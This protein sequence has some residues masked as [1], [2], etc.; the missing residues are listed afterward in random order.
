MAAAL[1]LFRPI[2]RHRNLAATTIVASALGYLERSVVSER[3]RAKY[4]AY[5]RGLYGKRARVFG[6][7]PTAGEAAEI[8]LSRPVLLALV[9][10][11]GRDPWARAKA[12][13][14]TDRWLD[15]RAHIAR[16]MLK[17]GVTTAASAGAQRLFERMAR[18]LERTPADTRAGRTRRDALLAALGSFEAPALL[19]RAVRLLLDGGAHPRDLTALFEAILDNPAAGRHGLALLAEVQDHLGQSDGD[20]RALRATAYLALLAAQRA[21]SAE[22]WRDIAKLA[23]AGVGSS[24]PAWLEQGLA[25]LRHDVEECIAFRARH[26]TGADALF[27]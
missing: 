27:K 18:A 10:R 15:T 6:F 14:L 9:G 19:D 12:R 7:S 8:T 22:E 5:V 4:S 3:T 13:R 1:T 16:G 20:T 2:A 26:Q 25:G 21:C 11:H 24:R 17:I 23:A